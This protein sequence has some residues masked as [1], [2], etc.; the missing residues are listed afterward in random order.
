MVP[1]ATKPATKKS[2]AAAPG[3][4]LAKKTSDVG[5]S[6]SVGV[7][8][9]STVKKGD[10]SVKVGAQPASR[11]IAGLGKWS[12]SSHGKDN[13]LVGNS[14]VVQRGTAC[15]VGFFY[16]SQYYRH[17]SDLVMFRKPIDDD[18]YGSRVV[19]AK[20]LPTKYA[21]KLLVSGK[22]FVSSGC[23]G[24]SNTSSKASCSSLSTVPLTED[25]RNKIHAK[26]L[27]AE[28]K[29]DLVS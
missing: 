8:K 26:I 2:P 15:F 22:D 19:K 5:K 11:G 21:Q 9:T 17:D 23:E 12:S 13:G 3:K 16:S 24:G 18:C 7:R 29:G 25:E 6:T 10:T 28:M 14:Q 20:P 27:K 4:T 1:T